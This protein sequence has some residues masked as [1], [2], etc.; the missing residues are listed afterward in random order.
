MNNKHANGGTDD[1]RHHR[2]VVEFVLQ[3]ADEMQ[4]QA[5][6]RLG[7]SLVHEIVRLFLT[8]LIPDAHV[9]E[10][11]GQLICRISFPNRANARRFI[12]QWGG[13]IIIPT[14]SD[15]V[16]GRDF[17]PAAAVCSAPQPDRAAQDRDYPAMR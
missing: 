3:I 14:D 9:L 1:Q 7:V 6:E 12:A 4:Q 17:S 10:P 16:N 8:V 5:L 2:W 15:H 13:R 11:P